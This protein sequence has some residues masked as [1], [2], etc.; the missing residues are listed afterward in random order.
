MKTTIGQ[1]NRGDCERRNPWEIP[2][3]LGEVGLW[4]LRNWWV[5]TKISKRSREPG[6][7]W[8]PGGRNRKSIKVK[9]AQDGGQEL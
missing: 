9:K 3:F 4:R 7:T 6:D 8:L 2:K 5:Q 1:E